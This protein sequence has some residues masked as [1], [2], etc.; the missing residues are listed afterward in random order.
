MPR[1]A[2]DRTV[3]LIT[4]LDPFTIHNRDIETY[5]G[6]VVETPSRRAVRGTRHLYIP[7]RVPSWESPARE[8]TRPSVAA[9]LFDIAYAASLSQHANL[10]VT[11]SAHDLGHHTARAIGM[12]GITG[13]SLIWNW[14]QISRFL[15]MFDSGD[16]INEFVLVL[17]RQRYSNSHPPATSPHGPGD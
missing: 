1:S 5:S 10:L 17:C 12:Y 8:N 6:H 15:C 11:K 4:R 9:V 16:L 14:W 13:A 7:L 2:T 3:S